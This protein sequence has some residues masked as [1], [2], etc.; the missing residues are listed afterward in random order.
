MDYDHLSIITKFKK[1]KKQ[2]LPYH[3]SFNIIIILAKGANY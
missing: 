1:K 2:W 3:I